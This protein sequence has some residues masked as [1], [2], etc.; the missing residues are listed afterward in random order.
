METPDQSRESFDKHVATA[1]NV[2]AT[3]QAFEAKKTADVA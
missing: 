2:V 1:A 3:Q